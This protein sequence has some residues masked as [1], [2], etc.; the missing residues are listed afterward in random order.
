MTYANKLIDAKK[1]SEK[2]TF[3]IIAVYNL[4]FFSVQAI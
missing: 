2:L 3:V 4:L 1:Y